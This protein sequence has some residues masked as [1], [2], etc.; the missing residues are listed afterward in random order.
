M[1]DINPP[2][3]GFEICER[4]RQASDVPIILLLG[5]ISTK[6]DKFRASDTAAPMIILLGPSRAIN[7]LLVCVQRFGETIEAVEPQFES[8]DLKI[9]FACRRVIVNNRF[10]HLTPKE[11]ELLRHLVLNQGKPVP[12]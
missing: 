4:I 6:N 12:T 2:E 7:L 10:I 9:D 8:S 5:A 3:L 11:L 1:L